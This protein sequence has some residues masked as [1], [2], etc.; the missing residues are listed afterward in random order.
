VTG[1][2]L[3]LRE[4]LSGIQSAR[5][6]FAGHQRVAASSEALVRAVK[7]AA[8]EKG[9]LLGLDEGVLVHGDRPLP[10]ATARSP[11]LVAALEAWGAGGLYLDVDAAE[12]DVAALLGALAFPPKGEDGSILPRAP[13]AGLLPEGS[14]REGVDPRAGAPTA[15][16]RFERSRQARRATC[17]LLERTT[18]DLRDGVGIDVDEVGVAAR[19][20]AELIASSPE[21]ALSLASM[22]GQDSYTFSHTVNVTVL[23]LVAARPYVRDLDTMLRLAQAALLHDVGKVEV[24]YEV[25]YKRGPYTPEEWAMMRT[26]PVRGAEILAGTK[27]VDDLAVMA[28]FGH[29]LRTD[30]SGYP[31]LAVPMRPHPFVGLLSIADVYEALTAERPYKKRM[32]PDR[33]M[34]ILLKEAGRQFEARLVRAFARAVGMFPVGTYVRLSDGRTGLV[35]RTFPEHPGLPRV[36][37]LEAGESNEASETVDLASDEARARGLRIVATLDRAPSME[38]L[39]ASCA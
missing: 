20:T 4:L 34:E 16:P 7:E 24:P 35:A 36:R 17:A 23:T 30:G 27:G 39:I 3:V 25:L 22:R 15:D 19:E 6:Y 14:V 38:D 32:P 28:A 37:L 21:T 31:P 18:E 2:D 10:D 29:H 9:L 26:H 8:P 13:G 33:A 12:E 1:L 5:V 11:A